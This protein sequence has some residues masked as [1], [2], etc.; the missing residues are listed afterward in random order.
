M[1]AT[2][3]AMLAASVAMLAAWGCNA[4]TGSAANI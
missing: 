3:V 1:F 4:I 2:W